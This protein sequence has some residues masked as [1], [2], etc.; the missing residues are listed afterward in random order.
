MPQY[1]VLKRKE[2]CVLLKKFCNPPVYKV[3]DIENDDIYIGSDLSHAESVF[4]DYNLA[5]I[6]AERKKI[7]E[8]WLDEY[9]GA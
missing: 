9:A 7:F 6:R 4:Q 5:D 8:R 3:K 2:D 1:E